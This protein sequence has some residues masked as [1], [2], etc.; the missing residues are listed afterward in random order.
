MM[1]NISLYARVVIISTMTA[2]LILGIN[3][4][5]Q[6]GA[7]LLFETGR[8]TFFSQG[9][10]IIFS[11]VFFISFIYTINEEKNRKRLT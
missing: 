5:L 1:N 10:L 7:H 6:Y 4:G 3:I 11:I 8:R 9:S 2:L